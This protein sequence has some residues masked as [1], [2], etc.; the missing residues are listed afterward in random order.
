MRIF[1]I[2]LKKELK[3][4][5]TRQFVFT[6]AAMV[7]IFYF[8]GKMVGGQ[9]KVSLMN[10]ISVIDMDKSPVSKTIIEELKSAKYIVKEKS[11]TNINKMVAGG[12][13][14][15]DLFVIVIPAGLGE[16]LNALKK[17]KIKVYAVLRKGLRSSEISSSKIRKTLSDIKRRISELMI[18][19][20]FRG[21][22][23][24]FVKDPISVDEFVIANKTAAEIPIKHVLAY[25]RSQLMLFPVV[26]FLVVIYASQIVMTAVASEKE[27]KTLEILLSSPINRKMLVF[28][29]I[30]ASGL[31]AFLLSGGY[32][33]GMRSFMSGVTGQ[34]SSMTTSSQSSLIKLGL[35]INPAGYLAIGI[36]ILFC[37]LCAL[38]VAIILGV[39]S[40]DVKGTQ[41]S[42]T[43]LM[44]VLL[45]SY[46][47]P[48]FMDIHK[49]SIPLKFLV[50]AIPFTHAFISPENIMLGNNA[51]VFWGIVYQAA[52]FLTFVAIAARIFSG[53]TILTL[54]FRFKG[55]K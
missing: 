6:L 28:S 22:D 54:K 51:A 3:E 43:P 19:R 32:M 15:K 24:G 36:S 49:L 9:N 5:L 34:V 47:L 21:C 20:R 40:E 10:E 26:I 25:M 35:M 14:E 45:L 12:K 17:Q 30:T 2:L 7:F 33:V 1:L 48:M 39:L 27:N 41:A 37:I 52:V 8:V 13:F 23:A 42:I 4:L 50:L 11:C 38:S 29:K 16:N 53:E 46:L 44:M 55:L 18:K 31:I